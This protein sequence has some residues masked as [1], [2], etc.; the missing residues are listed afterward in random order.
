MIK[1]TNRRTNGKA[2]TLKNL[3]TQTCESGEVRQM[4]RR[5]FL[6]TLGVSGLGSAMG[7]NFSSGDTPT[8]PNI[9][10]IVS[11]DNNPYIGAY[12]D[13]L[14]QTPTLDRLAADGILYEHCFSAAPVCAPSR[15]TLITGVNAVSCGPAHH[16]RA[17]GRIP[18]SMRGFPAYLR[19]AGYY[20]SNN[21]KT[22]YNAPIDLKDTWDES[23]RQ[24]HWR[25]RP[26]G[27]PFFSVFNFE[28]THESQVFPEN[29]AKYTPLPHPTDPAQVRLPAYHPDTPEMRR[30]RANYYD[31]MARLDAQ[32]AGLLRQLEEDGLAEDTIV[33]YYS[34]NG[35][36]L[37]RSKRFCYDSGLHTALIVRFPKK[38]AHLA[39]APPGS[40]ISAPVGSVDFAPTVLHLAG[41]KAPGYMQGKAFLAKGRAAG[42]TYAFSF[43]NRMDERY[44]MV[45]TLRGV[46]YRYIRNYMPHRIYGQHVEYL[47]QQ[48]G[49][50]VWE[51][52]HRQ[53]SFSGPQRAFW[54][55][56]P[57]EELY[58]LQ[59]DPDEVRNLAGDAGRQTI[60]HRMRS[61]LDREMLRVNDNGFIPEGSAEEGFLEAK[62]KKR[63]PL[64]RLLRITEKVCRRDPAF[65]PE[66]RKWMKEDNDCI[67]FWGAMGCL[68][69]GRQAA[70]AAEPLWEMLQDRSP[71]IQ[72]VAAEA[73]CHMGKE[74]KALEK[75]QDLLLR[76]AHPKIRLQAAN[77][78]E[79]IGDKA[80]PILASLQRAME[81][82]DDYVLRSV[83]HTIAKLQK[84]VKG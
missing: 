2:F 31:Q 23:S 57:F 21:A 6:C 35:G 7:G 84:H 60:L 62:D 45:R 63:Y 3:A 5:D 72:V 29:Q 33:F 49:V 32:V 13:P 43:R 19:E 30:D 82:K 48:K 71:Q 37:P 24:A 46:R 44:D 54:E 51:E 34:D 42:N 18:R 11:E 4:Q 9:L 10:W 16:M 14:A 38:W 73:L 78:I 27:K 55:E 26:G 58:D 50:G 83:R 79:N 52:L 66:I 80:I 68:M 59:T 40:R 64:S 39:P 12:G 15:F 1:I 28:V 56:K 65:L 8:R 81:D 25:K 20:C 22:D 47:W 36:V 76:H 61:A 77:A 70:P 67:R 53:G 41:Q 75:L 74:E 17:Q 69:L